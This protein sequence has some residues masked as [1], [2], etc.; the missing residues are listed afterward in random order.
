MKGDWLPFGATWIL[1]RG[2]EYNSMLPVLDWGRLPGVTSPHMVEPPLR[3]VRQPEGFVGGVSDGNYG[4]AAM[5]FDESE[6]QPLVPVFKIITQGRK[7]WF[8]FDREMLALGAGISSVSDQP[9]GTTLNQTGLR[10]PVLTDGHAIEPGE[11]KV[12][13]GSWV[14]HDEIGYVLLAS[15]AATV[16]TGTQTGE[17]RPAR[18]MNPGPPPAEQVF[19]LWIDHGVQPHD[20]QYAYA[21]LPGTNA[22]QLADWVAH[23][24]VRIITNTPEQQAVINNQL[25]VA[26]IVFY[27]P[28]SVALTP[29]VTVKVDHPCIAMLVKHAKS[30]R[31]AVSS[32]GGEFLSVHLT[33][34]TPQ[35]EKILNF[36]MP[37]G[38][39]AGKSQVLEAPVRW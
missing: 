39:M 29:G 7:S 18:M 22:Q 9:V 6:P 4:A 12:A 35:K 8:F 27:G 25:G 32:P 37:S 21:V 17:A 15:A 34:T 24:P 14:L 5:I 28:G 3:N 33:L 26:E 36:E 1:R 30:T 13:Q 20:A 31:I 11:T 16:N 19:S 10:G 38:D 2:D 23:P